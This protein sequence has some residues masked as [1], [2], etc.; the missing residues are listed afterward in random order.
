MRKAF[1]AAIAALFSITLFAQPSQAIG[2]LT[3]F[4][5]HPSV[6]AES[7]ASARYIKD[8]AIDDGRLYLGY[9]NY[10]ANT[11]PTDVAYVNLSTR[12][13]GVAVTAPTEEINTYRSFR[14][15]LYAPW[16][17]PRGSGTT[18][19][20]GYSTNEGS[21]RNVFTTPAGH[22]YDYTELGTTR[23]LAGAIAYGGAGVWV[24]KNGGP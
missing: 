10:T 2:S 7:L 24:S 8:L 23:L 4:A 17:D 3:L 6:Q 11:G 18:V 19:N 20:G 21:W 9:G 13:T 16:I 12:A 5:S 1:V 15:N 22:V 14:G